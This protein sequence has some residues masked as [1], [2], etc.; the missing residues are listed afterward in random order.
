MESNIHYQLPSEDLERKIQGIEGLPEL[1]AAIIDEAQI[2]IDTAR[3]YERIKELEAKYPRAAAYLKA[4]DYRW[5]AYRKQ[6]ALGDRAMYRI[7]EGEDHAVV[8]Q[9]MEDAWATW[10]MAQEG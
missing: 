7:L 8:I 4:Q 9:E 1:M 6:S 10:Q 2:E 5:S 3:Y